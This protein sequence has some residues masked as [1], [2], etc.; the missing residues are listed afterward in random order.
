MVEHVFG[1]CVWWW[2]GG[3][4][5]YFGI[6]K[7]GIEENSL[8]TTAWKSNQQQKLWHLKKVLNE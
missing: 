5:V 1:V 7:W 6:G 4:G 2:W 8:G 3:V